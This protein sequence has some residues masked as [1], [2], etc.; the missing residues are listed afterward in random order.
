MVPG[1]DRGAIST[2]P[3]TNDLSTPS[4]LRSGAEQNLEEGGQSPPPSPVGEEEEKFQINRE[5]NSPSNPRSRSPPVRG[6]VV[7][8][9]EGVPD[10]NPVPDEARPPQ[11]GKPISAAAEAAKASLA[12]MI[13]DPFH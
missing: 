6:A 3:A 1:N 11:T 12:Q 5:I 10:Q 13:V 4:P 2:G 7:P 8:S 9:F